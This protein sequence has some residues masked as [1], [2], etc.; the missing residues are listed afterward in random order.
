[1]SKKKILGKLTKTALDAVAPDF[2]DSTVNVVNQQ[3][4][5]RKD[6]IKIPDVISLPIDEASSILESYNFKFSKVLVNPDIKYADKRSLTVLKISPKVGWDVD[7]KTFV[8]FFY[9]DD[10]VIMKS[11]ELKNAA[12]LKKEQQKK[13]QQ[14]TLHNLTDSTVNQTKKMINKFDFH[15]HK[16]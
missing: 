8:K 1:M 2:V 11:K 16:E 12:A 15:K 7:P 4:E 3:L 14:E 13:E 9:A 10:E 5:K 6:Y